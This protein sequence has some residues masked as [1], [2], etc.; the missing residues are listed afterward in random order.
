MGGRAVYICWHG[1][2]T[3]GRRTCSIQAICWQLAF[4]LLQLHA[5][6]SQ[7][8]VHTYTALTTV[9]PPCVC[10]RQADGKQELYGGALKAAELRTFLDGF[11]PSQPQL[12][13][14]GSDKSGVK[15]P[16]GQLAQVEVHS[17]DTG[18]LTDIDQKDPMWL[19]SF[20]ASTGAGSGLRTGTCGCFA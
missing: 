1:A 9:P 3:A 13:G 12:E 2:V 10:A 19:V 8:Y 11:A 20:Y 16:L 5:L 15:D 17:L 18:N 4:S 7:R 6:L 14:A